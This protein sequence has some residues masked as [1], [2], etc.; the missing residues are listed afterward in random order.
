MTYIFAE[1]DL[2]TADSRD[3]DM[4]AIWHH[5]HITIYKVQHH[6][7]HMDRQEWIVVFGVVVVIGA[8]CLRGFGSRTKY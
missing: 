1:T 7:T 3:R 6:A 5:L 8:L 4:N 2:H